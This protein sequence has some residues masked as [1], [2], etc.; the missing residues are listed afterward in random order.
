MS[1]GSGS[2]ITP[3]EAYDLLHKWI[4]EETEVQASF[5][6]AAMVTAFIKG[7]L[8][9]APEQQL[10]LVERSQKIGS[11]VICFNPSLAISRKYADS[12]AFRQ[13]TAELQAH[14]A[15]QFGSTLIFVFPDTSQLGLWEIAE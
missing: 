7:L 5:S 4:T 14:G 1:A 12:R 6:T 13:P 3:Q 15:P 2:D 11:A 8:K 10:C 9:T